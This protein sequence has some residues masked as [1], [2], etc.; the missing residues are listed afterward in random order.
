MH[1]EARRAGFPALCISEHGK[2]RKTPG[3]GLAVSPAGS[4]RIL[5]TPVL[6][7]KAVKWM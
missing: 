5:R 7:V 1:P 3:N 2:R 4:Y 6:G